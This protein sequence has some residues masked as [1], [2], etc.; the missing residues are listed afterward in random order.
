MLCLVCTLIVCL[1]L[2][3]CFVLCCIAAV[4]TLVL[5]VL[6]GIH[7]CVGA[8]AGFQR[9]AT[10]GSLHTPDL[11]RAS[12]DFSLAAVG[13]TEQDISLCE[14]KHGDETRRMSFSGNHKTSL[15]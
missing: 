3:V 7:V 12:S 9:R 13:T 8:D 6:T 2:F 14:N 15:K 5:T 1:C 11:Q 10:A 4:H